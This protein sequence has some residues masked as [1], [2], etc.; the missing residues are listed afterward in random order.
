MRPNDGAG[1]SCKHDIVSL[2]QAV[3]DHAVADAL[4]ALF[5]L[6]EQTEVPGHCKA[7]IA[8]GMDR[9]LNGSSSFLSFGPSTAISVRTAYR[10]EFRTGESAVP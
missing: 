8:K 2:F 3:T 10:A 6:I 4:L 9:T 1:P 7:N 5:E